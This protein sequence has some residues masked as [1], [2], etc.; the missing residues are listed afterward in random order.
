MS[1][2]PYLLFWWFWVFYWK[3]STYQKYY[4][5]PHLAIASLLNEFI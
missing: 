2:K 1:L 3:K 4:T 5:F